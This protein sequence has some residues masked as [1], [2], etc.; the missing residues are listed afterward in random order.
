M[1]IMR[2]KLWYNSR[3][4]PS[5]T[6]GQN[7]L[8]HRFQPCVGSSGMLNAVTIATP[9]SLARPNYLFWLFQAG[10]DVY[11]EKKTTF[12]FLQGKV[13]WW[14]A[15][16]ESDTQKNLSDW[17]YANY[18]AGDNYHRV[19]AEII[20]YRKNW[21]KIKRRPLEIYWQPLWFKAHFLQATRPLILIGDMFGC[22]PAPSFRMA[23]EKKCYFNN[24]RYFMAVLFAG[25]VF[26]RELLGVI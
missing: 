10:K 23:P 1:R 3:E 22:G 9:G 15:F 18:H 13:S 14:L 12:L 16:S 19:V 5:C 6:Q 4:N 7:N 20:Q 17:V 26:F 24:Y 11:S 8:L 25:R 2:R 21:V